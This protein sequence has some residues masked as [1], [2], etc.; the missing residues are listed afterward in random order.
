[1]ITV[2]DIKRSILISTAEEWERQCRVLAS[3]AKKSDMEAYRNILGLLRQAEAE[4]PDVDWIKV[5]VE[6]AKDSAVEGYAYR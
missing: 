1:M 4:L 6:K 2:D 3:I 5:R